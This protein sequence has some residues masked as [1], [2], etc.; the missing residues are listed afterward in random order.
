M[1]KHSFT[2]IENLGNKKMKRITSFKVKKDHIPL[3]TWGESWNYFQIEIKL[4]AYYTKVKI[5]LSMYQEVRCVYI[6]W[7]QYWQTETEVFLKFKVITVRLLP[8]ILARKW[9]NEM[10]L[11]TNK[12]KKMNLLWDSAAQSE[13]K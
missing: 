4:S 8:W 12:V 10:F 7:I 3:E 1:I 11:V 9:Y 13:R 6:P 2:C 5:Q